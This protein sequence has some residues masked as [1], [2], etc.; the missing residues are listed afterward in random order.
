MVL[1][2]TH[3]GLKVPQGLE[4]GGGS[5]SGCRDDLLERRVRDVSGSVEAWIGGTHR[6]VHHHP[7]A[8]GQIDEIL[9][10]LWGLDIS[11]FAAELAVIN[12]CRQD[13]DSQ[14]N[15]PRIAVRDFFDL[16]TT[17]SLSFPP[18][19]NLRG[20]PARV[21]IALPSFDVVVGNPPYVR[22]QQLDDL[23]VTYKRKLERVAVGAGLSAA[24]K[25]DAFAFFIL[26]ARRFVK[27]GGRLG[28]VTSAAWLTSEYGN[29]LKTFILHE[30]QPLLLLFSTAEPFFPVVAIDTVVIVLEALPP[31][32]SPDRPIR[33]VTLQRPL[34]EL[35]P[36]EGDERYW[37]SLSGLLADLE[38]SPPGQHEGFMVSELEASAER[39]ALAQEPK[40]NRNW[41]RPFRQTPIYLELFS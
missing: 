9:D 36:D 2:R 1:Q 14:S 8:L 21:D 37:T 30:F 23:D 31:R 11:A 16:K 40:V 20:S 4:R 19:Q 24:A 5:L 10:Q 38:S 3:A 39:L 35:L 12:L 22:S 29:V 25:F 33:F 6:A 27:P 26:H 18:A 41:A 17:D 13:L 7:A 28:F 34:G 32:T 15:F